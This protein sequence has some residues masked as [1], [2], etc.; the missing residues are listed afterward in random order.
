MARSG[1]RETSE[2]LGRGV[3]MLALFTGIVPL[4]SRWC[5]WRNLLALVVLILAATSAL[6]GQAASGTGSISGRVT[7]PTGA[8]MLGASI[9]VR[10]SGTN[11]ARTLES[12][13]AGLYEVVALQP[14]VYDVK[15]AKAGFATLVRSGIT[16]SVGQAAVVNATMQ[17][18][19]T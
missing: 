17:V 8:I 10:N 3:C 15:I 5:A 12:N 1:S 14:G 9:E 16:V 7:D 18:S 4:S 11:V 2:S 13:D 19:A 6:F